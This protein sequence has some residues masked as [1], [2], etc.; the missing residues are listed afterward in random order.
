MYPARPDWLNKMKYENVMDIFLDITVNNI[1]FETEKSAYEFL[2]TQ[3]AMLGNFQHLDDEKIASQIVCNYFD[4]L[5]NIFIKKGED[6]ILFDYI[7]NIGDIARYAFDL[8]K[9]DISKE[10]I[11]IAKKHNILRE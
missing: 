3:S 11:E 4:E 6:C 1:E 7:S 10:A 9:S 5:K 8:V 2:E